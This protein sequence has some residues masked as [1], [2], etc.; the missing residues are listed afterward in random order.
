[1]F[2]ALA[3]DQE[4]VIY[5]QLFLVLAFVVSSPISGLAR[6]PLLLISDLV[7]Q[8]RSATIFFY[9]PGIRIC[10]VFARV[11]VVSP[12][13]QMTAVSIVMIGLVRNRRKFQLIMRNCQH[14][15]KRE[16]KACSKSSSCFSVFFSA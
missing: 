2:F 1:M 6:W 9:L 7:L 13:M 8:V 10:V 16:R 15:G 5:S 4:L 12:V 14:E 3:C 11:V